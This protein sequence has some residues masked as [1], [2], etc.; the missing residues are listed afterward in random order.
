MAEATEAK[1]SSAMLAAVEALAGIADPVEIPVFL[2]VSAS[3]VFVTRS[4]YTRV[5][6]YTL[7]P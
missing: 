5:F 2:T 1:A 3:I 7:I 6:R 4:M